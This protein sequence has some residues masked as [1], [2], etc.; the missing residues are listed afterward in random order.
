[1]ARLKKALFFIHP[2]GWSLLLQPNVVAGIQRFANHGRSSS[3]AGGILLGRLILDT[4]DISVDLISEPTQFDKRSRFNFFR[5]REPHQD[6][7]NKAWDSST[8]TCIYLGEWHCHP[9]DDPTPSGHDLKNWKQI[10]KSAKYE[11]SSLI[12]LIAGYKRIRLWE[13]KKGRQLPVELILQG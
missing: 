8:G 2:D 5:S 9:E 13:S 7:V 12:F 1:M 3:E 11:Q 10:V 6:I 4:E